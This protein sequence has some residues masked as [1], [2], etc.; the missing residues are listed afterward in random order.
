MAAFSN[1]WAISRRWI[2]PRSALCSAAFTAEHV[3]TAQRPIDPAAQAP[4]VSTARREGRVAVLLCNLG[5]PDRADARSVRRYLREFLSD[6]RVIEASPLIWQ[7]ILNLILIRRPVKT[8][9]AYQTVWNNERN[10]APLITTVRSQA[11]KLEAALAAEGVTV[12]WAM[13]YAKRSI[14]ER[15]RALAAAGADRILVAPLY[16]QYSASA[17][18]TVNDVAFAA[19]QKMRFQPYVRTLP[20]YYNDPVY[21]EA[22]A[23]SLNKT[24]AALPFEPKKLLITFHGLPRSYIDGGDPY[25]GQTVET[26]RLLQERLGWPDERLMITYQS[27]FG[28]AEWTKPYTEEVIAELPRRGV[29]RILVMM[30][31]FSADCL[32]T[33]EEMR[34]RNAELFHENG[35][36]DYAAVPCLNDS[37]EGMRVLETVVRRELQGW[38]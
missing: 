13:R 8:A 33:L 5:S 4:R 10:E 1:L 6:R 38:I 36:V 34:V 7:P 23:T 17:T 35:G 25:E 21:I 24:L 9:H 27:R 19:L 32:E 3:L 31:G 16:P 12:D 28:N 18:A 29:K 26:T 11:E 37:D 2:W 30:P 14:G 20:A 22:L 15:V